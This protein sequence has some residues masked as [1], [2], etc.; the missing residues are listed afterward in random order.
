M[1][2]GA[3]HPVLFINK[4]WACTTP[5]TK[6][7]LAGN[8]AP[9]TANAPSTP[10]NHVFLGVS[11]PMSEGIKKEKERKSDTQGSKAA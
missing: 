2:P 10:T 3:Q 11:C 4:L 8:A 9:D 7:Q 1:Q 6:Q 5:T